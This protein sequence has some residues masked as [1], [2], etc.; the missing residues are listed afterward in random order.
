MTTAERVEA[1]VASLLSESDL[2][3][4]LYDVE[5][6][7]GTLRVLVD[8][9]GG[10]DIDTLTE[11]SRKISAALDEEDPLPGRYVLEVS[12][13]GLERPLRT[14]RHFAAAIGSAVRIRTFDDLD[15]TRRVA[16]TILDAGDESLTVECDDGETRAVRYTDIERARTVFE[17]QRG[18]KPGTKGKKRTAGKPAGAARR[19]AT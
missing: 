7:G 12:S 2:D 1:L 6:A 14:P 18:E 9:P 16:G 10:V 13:P 19:R 15:G 17:W 8:R 3:A 11:L 5:H 4:E